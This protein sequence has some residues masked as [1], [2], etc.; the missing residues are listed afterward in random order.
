MYAN[1][2]GKKFTE[3]ESRNRSLLQNNEQR[4]R[5]VVKSSSS[6]EHLQNY[7]VNEFDKDLYFPP[8]FSQRHCSTMEDGT[9][10]ELGKIAL[11]QFLNDVPL[12]MLEGGVKNGSPQSR[13]A[14]AQSGLH[15]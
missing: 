4:S 9:I 13:A 12:G 14:N 2:F 7:F 11:E 3:C 10:D 5:C 1:A 8:S 15:F 6:Q